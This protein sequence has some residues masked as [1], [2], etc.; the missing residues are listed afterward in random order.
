[1]VNRLAWNCRLLCS[2]EIC[3]PRDICKQRDKPRGNC[4]YIDIYICK[5]FLQLCSHLEL[6]SFNT[7]WDIEI[8]WLQVLKQQLWI[9]QKPLV[10]TLLCAGAGA[11]FFHMTLPVLKGSWYSS[12]GFQA[13]TVSSRGESMVMHTEIKREYMFL[14]EQMSQMKPVSIL[15]QFSLPHYL[16]GSCVCVGTGHD[17]RVS[18]ETP[19]W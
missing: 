15:M 7:G 18:W 5:S 8:Q 1:M 11:V 9:V 13:D 14:W 6:H 19:L 16:S 3:K 12:S 4:I 2:L 17:M 10:T